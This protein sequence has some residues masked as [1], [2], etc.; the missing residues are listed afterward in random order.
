MGKFIRR[1]RYTANEYLLAFILV[2]GASMFFLAMSTPV[3][4]Q[5]VVGLQ[6]VHANDWMAHLQ[7]HSDTI[8]GL[9]LMC[10]YL[11]FDAFTPNWQ[12]SSFVN[13]YSS[14][15]LNFLNFHRTLRPTPTH[16]HLTNDV[17]RERIQRV[18]LPHLIGTPMDNDCLHAIHPWAWGNFDG[19]FASF[20]GLCIWTGELMKYFI[21]FCKFSGLHLHDHQTVRSSGLVHFDDHPPNHLHYSLLHLLCPPNFTARPNRVDPRVQCNFLRYLQQIQNKTEATMIFIVQK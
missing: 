5:K 6:S 21:H 16:L 10:G 15:I 7:N 14:S 12:K 8:S 20:H 3:E 13:L 4:A 2:I 19:L 1:Q 9:V 18:A 11:L 17:C